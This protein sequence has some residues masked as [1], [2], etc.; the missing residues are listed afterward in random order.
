MA[1]LLDQHISFQSFAK[2]LFD[3]MTAAMLLILT[4][5]ILIIV[6][7]AIKFDSRGPIIFKQV[8]IGKYQKKFNFYKF[9]SMYVGSNEAIHRDY[10]KNLLTKESEEKHEG[11][12]TYKLTHDPRI[13]RV[14]AFIRKTSID[15]LPQLINVLEGQMSMIG[16]RPAIS[17]EIEYHDKDML[18]RFSVK[19]G[20]T[21]LWQVNG[22]SALTYRQMVEM[23]LYYIEHWSL[24]LDIKIA[25][26]T[27]PQI[28]R[29]THVY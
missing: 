3:I 16:P 10:I 6:A 7:L 5:P 17:Y 2:R 29:F 18:K 27:L 19:P 13:T 28:L 1:H 22:R 15:E 24:W 21:G 8:R 26:K 23:D 11:L 9:R 25:F 4:S 14:G 20:I 12:T